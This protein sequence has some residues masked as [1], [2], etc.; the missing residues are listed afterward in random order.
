MVFVIYGYECWFH[1]N[2]ILQN[3]LWL[4]Y[5]QHVVGLSL[6]LNDAKI[7]IPHWNAGCQFLTILETVDNASS[8]PIQKPAN[9]SRYTRDD[10]LSFWIRSETF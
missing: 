1:H 8:I 5:F 6:N 3:K 10:T 2:C 4:N 7:Q 9:F